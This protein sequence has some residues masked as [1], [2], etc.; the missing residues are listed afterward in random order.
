MAKK[1][2]GK[3]GAGTKFAKIYGGAIRAGYNNDE[4]AAMA[5]KAT[6]HD[7]TKKESLEPGASRQSLFNR[8]FGIK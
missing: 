3:K 6:G 8:M 5:G 2:G 1:K 7:T 4:A